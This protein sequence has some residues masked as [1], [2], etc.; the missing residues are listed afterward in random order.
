MPS[1]EKK[2]IENLGPYEPTALKL[3]YVPRQ[4]SKKDQARLHSE[5]ENIIAKTP[6]KCYYC[7][8]KKF[9]NKND[10]QKHVLTKHQDK[11]CY[12][13][14]SDINILGIKAQGMLWEI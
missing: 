8:F 11:L 9:K 5:L 13:G 2:S 7:D 14:L 1:P 10:Y 6:P 3:S 12:P 4:K